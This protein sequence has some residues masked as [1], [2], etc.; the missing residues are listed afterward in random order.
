VSE[1]KVDELLGDLWAERNPTIALL[2]RS[3][4]IH[5]RLTAK[6][7]GEAEL[8]RLLDGREAAVRERLGDIIF[9]RDEE[10][11]EVVVGR[12]LRERRLTLAVA[13]S[14]TGGLLGHRITNVPGSSAYFDRG[15]VA[16]SN[17]AKTALLG[18]P[19]ELLAARGAVSAEVAAAMAEGMRAAA[20]T[21]LALGVTG[22]AGPAGG[23]PEKPVGLTYIALAHAGGV[24]A[25]EFRF[26]TDRDL[27]K[28][29]AAQMAL[30]LVRRHL[31]GLPPV[32]IL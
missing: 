20:G 3:G 16:Y 6:A 2:A 21:D 28:Q 27:N 25:H 29:R 7:E 26:F 13:E 12:L 24:A 32:P 11:L 18:V 14:C 8:T 10:S 4:E 30:D 22:I 15:L 23:T 17:Q 9:G 5:V 1:S 31:L 19:A